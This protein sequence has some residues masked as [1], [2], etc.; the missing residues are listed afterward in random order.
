MRD[1]F[2][3]ATS[4]K[5]QENLPEKLHPEK[6]VK[7]KKK[8]RNEAKNPISRNTPNRN[9]PINRNTPNRNTRKNRKT[10]RR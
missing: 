9:T 1:E 7:Y 6:T 8:R 10:R 2:A 5:D 4:K 3:K